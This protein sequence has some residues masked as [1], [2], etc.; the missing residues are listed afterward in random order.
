MVLKTKFPDPSCQITCLEFNDNRSNSTFL[1]R[2]VVSNVEMCGFAFCLPSIYKLRHFHKMQHS[3]SS[4]LCRLDH[5]CIQR[6][7][8]WSE[9]EAQLE[10]LN[11]QS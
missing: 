5:P 6:V 2:Q 4:D 8:D 3:D 11:L 9:V 7:T 10:V 1:F